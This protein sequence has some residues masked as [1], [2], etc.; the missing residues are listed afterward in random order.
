[1]LVAVPAASLYTFRMYK[2]IGQI[3]RTG[4]SRVS[5]T[6]SGGPERPYQSGI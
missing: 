3:Q 4:M 6:D 2:Q 5:A 1:M